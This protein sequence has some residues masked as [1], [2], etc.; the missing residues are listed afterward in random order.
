MRM[1]YEGIEVMKLDGGRQFFRGYDGREEG[2]HL[3]MRDQKT[4]VIEGRWPIAEV[5]WSNKPM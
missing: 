4:E 2:N 1:K 5:S 3:V